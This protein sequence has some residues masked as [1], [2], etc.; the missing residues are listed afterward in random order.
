MAKTPKNVKT[1]RQALVDK[2]MAEQKSGERARGYR[3][4]GVCVVVALLIVGAAAYRPIKDWWDQRSFND[5][6]LSDDRG[7]RDRSARSSPPRPRRAPR[8]TS[9]EGT[10]LDILGNPPAFGQHYDVPAAMDRKFYTTAD[11]P[12]LGTLIHNLEHGYTILWYDETAADDADM[13]NEIRALAKKLDT[14]DGNFRN[15]FKAVPWTS[16][17]RRPVP[18]RPAHR[19]HALVGR[20]RRRRRHGQAGRRHAVLLRTERRGPRGLHGDVP[21]RRLARARRGVT[22]RSVRGR[23][24]RAR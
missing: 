10:P 20:R 18:R 19:V 22:L 16:R 2:M 17:R 4:I 23:T 14:N 9:P 6:E 8:T 11:R 5:L 7:R 12:E 13:M 24:H 21:L 3:I 1:E 15:K